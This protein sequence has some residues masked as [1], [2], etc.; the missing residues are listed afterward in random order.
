MEDYAAAI[1]PPSG[2]I[3]IERIPRGSK[4]LKVLQEH[5]GGYIEIV[6]VKYNGRMYQAYVNEDGRSL[7]LAENLRATKAFRDAG[8]APAMALYEVEVV[9]CILGTMVICLENPS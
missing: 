3:K 1:I 4:E 9:D 7:E 5:V 2:E 8:N 6:R